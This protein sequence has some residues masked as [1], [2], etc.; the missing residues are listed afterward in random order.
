M[1]AKELAGKLVET[2]LAERPDNA[3]GRAAVL[4]N[5]LGSTKYEELFALYGTSTIS[6][7]QQE[8]CRW[9]QRWGSW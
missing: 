1:T 6:W 4:V 3:S 2:V 8:S 9:H 7:K 5:G